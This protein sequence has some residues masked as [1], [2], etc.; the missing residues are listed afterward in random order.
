MKK[1]NVVLL[2]VVLAMVIAI[3][4]VAGFSYANH[5]R[6]AFKTHFGF[7]PSNSY[8]MNERVFDSAFEADQKMVDKQLEEQA[9]GVQK[10]REKMESAA[11]G[12]PEKYEIARSSYLLGQKNCLES[13]AIAKSFGYNK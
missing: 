10:A 11:G 12:D 1:G 7:L 4:L 5:Q 2:G 6:E 13:Q 9:A 8:W 3:G